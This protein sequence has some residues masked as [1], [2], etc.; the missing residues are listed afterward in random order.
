M[1]IHDAR[2]TDRYNTLIQELKSQHIHPDDI[3]WMPSVQ[4]STPIAGISQAHRACIQKARDLGL[5]YV[6]IFEDDIKFTSPCSFRRYMDAFACLPPT[7]DLYFGGLLSCIGRRPINSLFCGALD[8]AGLQC[9][10]VH[11]RFYSAFLQAPDT[12]HIDRWLLPKGR[13]KA[14]ILVP[15]IAVQHDGFSDQQSR[16]MTH[17]TLHKSVDLFCTNSYEP[18][19][20]DTL[21]WP[22]G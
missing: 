13:A 8:I 2:R 9:Y 14:Y 6:T 3:H 18:L 4:A 17:S 19:S 20:C 7:W 16:H 22:S 21:E 5:P 15:Y 11:Q 1:V 12:I 10:T